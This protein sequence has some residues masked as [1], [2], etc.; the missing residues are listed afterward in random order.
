MTS[1]EQNSQQQK[2]SE[3]FKQQ[4]EKSLDQR[5]GDLEVLDA[6]GAEILSHLKDNLLN[7]FRPEGNL[8]DLRIDRPELEGIYKELLENK[9][10]RKLLEDSSVSDLDQFLNFIGF[11]ELSS[12]TLGLEKGP[13]VLLGDGN[14]LLDNG[15]K[16]VYFMTDKVEVLDNTIDSNGNIKV[17]IT[18]DRGKFRGKLKGQTQIHIGYIPRSDIGGNVTKAIS[19]ES[20]P[21][22]PSL[23]SKA[24]EVKAPE[25]KAPESKAPQ[26]K[27]TT[28]SGNNGSTCTGIRDAETGELIKGKKV[29]AN[30]SITWQGTFD[31]KSGHLTQGFVQT[32][33][34]FR[35]EG[36]F[37]ST[38]GKVI[39][40]EFTLE[41]GTKLKFTGDQKF[42]TTLASYQME[43]IHSLIELSKE[44]K[45]EFAKLAAKELKKNPQTFEGYIDWLDHL[46]MV[47]DLDPSRKEA[48]AD[49]VPIKNN[50]IFELLDQNNKDLRENTKFERIIRNPLFKTYNRI[51]AV[52]K[53][54][55]NIQ[56]FNCWGINH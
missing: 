33:S 39:D 10:T 17:K 44:E 1:P 29:S 24:P 51:D 47:C 37:S 12:N 14:I 19:E 40:G 50:Q 20:A 36:Q 5:I 35:M 8:A 41:N 46:Y 11:S 21:V 18:H 54:I 49:Q 48:L 32:N 23:E 28:W 34:G 25:S 43:L 16:G 7:F 56:F 53:V 45:E 4:V 13:T 6:K 3:R 42:A 30:G 9:E 52:I 27:E 38:S 26:L 22:T 31:S 2:P 55:E 15:G